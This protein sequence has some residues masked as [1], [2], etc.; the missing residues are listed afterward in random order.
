MSVGESVSLAKKWCEE[1]RVILKLAQESGRGKALLSRVEKISQEL[2]A[3][4][5]AVKAGKIP[6]TEEQVNAFAARF[7]A[8]T[9][10]LKAAA[11]EGNQDGVDAESVKLKQL[12]RELAGHLAKKAEKQAPVED[13]VAAAL[14]ESFAAEKLAAEEELAA[15][16]SDPGAAVIGQEIG[17]IQTERIDAAQTAHDGSK[18]QAAHDLL[19]GVAGD[20]VAA[21]SEAE[22]YALAL[23]GAEDEVAKLTQPAIAVDAGKIKTELIG[24]AKGKAAADRAV[25]WRFWIKSL[26]PAW[27]PSPRPTSTRWPSKKH[28]T[29]WTSSTSRSAARMSP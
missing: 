3:L 21:K 13:K 7:A 20:C 22:K 10:E 17:T 11:Q 27:P 24:V 29:S 23:Q 25:R 8:M 15:L 2:L 14:A 9:A 26:P 19:A 6:L 4:E 12:K 5:Q 18:H 28:R 16:R 1:A